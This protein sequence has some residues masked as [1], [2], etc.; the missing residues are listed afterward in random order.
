MRS[1]M[2]KPENLSNSAWGHSQQGVCV[3]VPYPVKI[4][5]LDICMIY[6]MSMN[7]PP[8]ILEA[9]DCVYMWA[10]WVESIP[11]YCSAVCVSLS[12]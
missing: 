5:N 1:C 10:V 2:S 7:G 12:S 8:R 11:D 9:D 3:C 6:V 4:A